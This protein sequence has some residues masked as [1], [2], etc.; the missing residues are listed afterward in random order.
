MIS[1]ELFGH[2]HSVIDLVEPVFERA[3]LETGRLVGFPAPRPRTS[4]AA[5]GRDVRTAADGRRPG[6][7]ADDEDFYLI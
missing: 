3:L 4:G 6:R 7:R 5:A 1:F 2:F